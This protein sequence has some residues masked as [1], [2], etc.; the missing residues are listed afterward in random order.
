MTIIPYL[1]Y[2]CY[3]RPLDL[4]ILSQYTQINF[5]ITPM[6]WYLF[7]PITMFLFSCEE[8]PPEDDD[9]EIVVV[10]TKIYAGKVSDW[11]TAMAPD[12]LFEPRTIC[13]TWNNYR[14]CDTYSTDH[15]FLLPWDSCRIKVALI[16][17]EYAIWLK[18]FRSLKA[19]LKI[20]GVPLHLGDLIN[21]DVDWVD[22]LEYW[23]SGSY[24]D[25]FAEDERQFLG[26][27]MNI[28]GGIL[29]GWLEF[30]SPDIRSIRIIQFAFE[31]A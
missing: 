19:E 30:A 27:R 24:Y 28:N 10:D 21:E 8:I 26:L 20:S 14:F 22:Y 9:D 17:T 25:D 13:Q 3:S 31:D 16:Y 1:G 12:T 11:M 4:Y 15:T 29:Y 7:I 2:P 18:L 6:R 5:N 23:N